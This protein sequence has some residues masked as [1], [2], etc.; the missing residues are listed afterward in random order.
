[1][2][3]T[4]GGSTATLDVTD[5]SHPGP[6]ASRGP[7]RRRSPARPRPPVSDRRARPT[8]P[9]PPRSAGT[10]S[11]PSGEGDAG[12]GRCHAAPADLATARE[13]Q[14]G[15]RVRREGRDRPLDLRD[16]RPRRL[17]RGQGPRFQ[18]S[19][20]GW[21]QRLVYRFGGGC[22]TTYSQG[23]DFASVLDPKL[24]LKGYAVTTSTLNTFQSACNTVLSAEVTMMVKQH[25][26]QTFGLPDLHHRRRRLGRFDPTA[27]DRAELPGPARRACRPS[28][29]SPTPS[30]SA[31]ASATA[32]CSTPTTTGAGSSL[33]DGA[34]RG[35][36]RPR[37]RPDLP[38]LAGQLR[39]GD[40]GQRLRFDGA[41]G[42]GLRPR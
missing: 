25:F 2:S 30:A 16:R 41:Q 4:I 27:P 12:A 8:A 3:V 21:N 5:H 23:S 11:R 26:I 18:P 24:L 38:A 28:C 29:R 20:T 22:G 36:Q 6:R 1:M 37:V 14:A 34:A 13:R 33:T 32:R 19:S 17:E 10:T 9:R 15:L 40:R 7:A 35:H 31:R 42:P 39:Q